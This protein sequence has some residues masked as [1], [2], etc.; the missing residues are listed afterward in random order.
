MIQI[1]AEIP[2]FQTNATVAWTEIQSCHF[3]PRMG[4]CYWIYVCE[5]IGSNSLFIISKKFQSAE[6]WTAQPFLFFH[7]GM[8]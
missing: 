3:F 6:L 2:Y 7:I 5:K 1:C 8:P 4:L